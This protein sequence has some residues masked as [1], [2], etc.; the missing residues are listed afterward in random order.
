[1]RRPRPNFPVPASGTNFA[2]FA[3]ATFGAS[4]GLG[5]A[6]LLYVERINPNATADITTTATITDAPPSRDVALVRAM[7]QNAKESSWREN[8]SNAIMAQERFV[9]PERHP[10]RSRDTDIEERGETKQA[11]PRD[12]FMKKIGERL[13]EQQAQFVQRKQQREED[14]EFF[15]TSWGQHDNKSER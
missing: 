2:K 5:Y 12:L 6:C 7:V 14:A 10:A 1:M 11:S 9:L 8:L 3:V 4:I 13:E 15:S